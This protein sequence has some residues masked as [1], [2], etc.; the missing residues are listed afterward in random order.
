MPKSPIEWTEFTINPLRFRNKE[1]ERVG[2]Y[3][4]K[5]SPGCK[6]CYASTMQKG[7]YLSGLEYIA[8][9]KEKGEL[10]LEEKALQQVL[11]RRKP[12]RFFW[13]DM[14]DMFGE[15]VPDEWIDRCFAV[16]ALT[17]QHT[18]QVLTKRAE[19][20]YSYMSN[21][22]GFTR[23]IRWAE[24]A[25][26]VGAR[27]VLWRCYDAALGY[28]FGFTRQPYDDIRD[29]PGIHGYLPNVH[30]GVSAEDQQRADERIP[31][32]LK[33]PAAVRFVSAEPLLGPID[34]ERIPTGQGTGD[35]WDPIVHMN[36][37]KRAS[38]LAPHAHWVIVGGESGPGARPCNIE[39]IRSIV[40]QCRDAGTACF[41]KQ[42]GAVP[43]VD[44]E[45]E[46]WA[47]GTFFGNRTG[48]PKYN[49]RQVI[50]R[51]RKGGSMDEW[52]TDLRVRQFPEVAHA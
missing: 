46:E 41:V 43:I 31:W 10:Y 23:S 33:T 11:N 6:N 21:S 52:P 19:R 14:T 28:F 9:N 29:W 3:C 18:H 1:T 42:L 38:V 25:M 7:P 8:T 44:N 36:P 49:G 4:E 40:R 16:M 12:T 17:P 32:L 45:G 35:E 47:D 24:A 20:M 27:R 15:W 26:S 48:D 13:C 22:P 5:I 34:F 50:L 51:D 39:W 37:F 30:L 2:H